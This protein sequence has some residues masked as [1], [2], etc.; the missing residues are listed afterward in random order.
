[1]DVSSRYLATVEHPILFEDI[2]RDD[3]RNFLL[4]PVEIISKSII[5]H[6]SKGFGPSLDM[7]I[8]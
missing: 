2:F 4:D 5:R 7:G 3:G 1:M 6:G 8:G